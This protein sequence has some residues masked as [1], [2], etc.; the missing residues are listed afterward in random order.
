MSDRKQAAVPSLRCATMH[1]TSLSMPRFGTGIA[2][3]QCRVGPRP[4]V[5]AAGWCRAAVA[6]QDKQPLYALVANKIDLEHL[7]AI[8]SDRHHK[9]AQEHGLL[10]YAVSAKTGEGVG[11][12]VQ[13][14][15][16]ELL[17]IRLSK[18]EQEQ[19]Q[20]VVRAEIVQYKEDAMPRNPQTTSQ[21][22]VCSIM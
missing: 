16:A 11:L 14:V 10:T 5:A 21:S 8:K 9:F 7:R 4:V 6:A 3:L 12:C 13:K 22:A 2:L 19:Q 20:T 18:Q 15:A 17:G 1:C